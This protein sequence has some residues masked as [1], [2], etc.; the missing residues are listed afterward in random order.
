MR[1]PL[2]PT[3]RPGLTFNNWPVTGVDTRE[4]SE[5]ELFFS[6]DCSALHIKLIILF[7][8]GFQNKT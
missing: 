2:F 7:T 1:T 5:L 4:D 3:N 8:D 6:V